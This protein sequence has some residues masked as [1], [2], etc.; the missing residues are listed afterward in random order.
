MQGRQA[1]RILGQPGQE[2]GGA[3]HDLHLPGRPGG[4]DGGGI[5]VRF[6]ARDGIDQRGIGG[7]AAGGAQ[8]RH[9][10]AGAVAR[11]AIG[12]LGQF[13]ELGGQG[14]QPSAFGHQHHGAGKAG[15]GLGLGPEQAE[16]RLGPVALA[17]LQQGKGAQPGGVGGHGLDIRLAQG[18]AGQ[19]I[20]VERKAEHPPGQQA[21]ERAR[22]LGGAGEPEA[23]RALL[24]KPQL[25]AGGPE[26]G[27]GAL[28][29]GGDIGVPGQA[30]HVP[31]IGD[32]ACAPGGQASPVARQGNRDAAGRF[33]ALA[34]LGAGGGNVPCL[35]VPVQGEQ[36]LGGLAAQQGGIARRQ[37]AGGAD[38]AGGGAATGG[39]AHHTVDLR[40]A[41]Q[42]T[43]G[44]LGFL[45]DRRGVG[46][47]EGGEHGGGGNG[48]AARE[49]ALQ[50]GMDR[51]R[52]GQGGPA[53]QPGLEVLGRGAGMRAQMP[54]GQEM[55][56]EFLHQRGFEVEMQGLA[57]RLGNVAAG[58]QREQPAPPCGFAWRQGL[59]QGGATSAGAVGGHAGHGECRILVGLGL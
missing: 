25:G 2:T 19:G 35:L 31:R 36:D 5:E 14:G 38:G 47:G 50:Q 34:C 11:A 43:A 24:A 46:P 17:D 28:G 6:D 29:R 26:G 12:G 42:A 52:V 59:E 18:F 3:G 54:V 45:R 48:G 53:H 8:A 1:L 37:G 20:A 51:R 55:A 56:V 27:G 58:L 23:M 33:G 30:E 10:E 49:A 7:E 16:L 21:V 39:V 15:G 41:G 44:R 40:Q 32:A 13:G 4:G 9:G 57:H 22:L